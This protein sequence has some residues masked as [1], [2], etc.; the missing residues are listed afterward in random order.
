M[1]GIREQDG[2]RAAETAAVKPGRA[3][4]RDLFG[5][6]DLAEEFGIT[7]RTIRFYENKDLIHPARVNGAR[8]Y[9]RRDR[10]RLALILRAKAIG[11]TLS[12]I[13]H[14]L[15]LYGEH[16]EGQKSQLEYVVSESTKAID[17]LE[18]K[19]ALIDDTLSELKAIRKSCLEC[20]KDL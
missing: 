6:A 13:R 10:A 18:T 1:N 15:D 9:T 17:D 16:G 4:G 14:F 11:S 2:A 12:Q 5:I 7:T 20:L 8:V 3:E 19:R